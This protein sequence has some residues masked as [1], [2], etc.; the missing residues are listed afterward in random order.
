MSFWRYLSSIAGIG[1]LE[2]AAAPKRS[3]ALGPQPGSRKFD[4][5]IQNHVEFQSSARSACAWTA[6]YRHGRGLSEVELAISSFGFLRWFTMADILRSSSES[7]F[8]RHLQASNFSGRFAAL[9]LIDSVSHK[10]RVIAAIRRSCPGFHPHQEREWGLLLADHEDW[11]QCF[12]RGIVL[13]TRALTYSFCHSLGYQAGTTDARFGETVQ[14]LLRDDIW[15]AV[16]DWNAETL[17]SEAA[18][19]LMN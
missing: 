3:L 19:E 16:H 12:T 1:E 2:P 13:G 14:R 4:K 10:S 5:A 8:K 11:N 9:D 6:S 7:E 15:T 17:G 18:D